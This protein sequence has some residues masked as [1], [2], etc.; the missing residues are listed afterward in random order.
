MQDLLYATAA[1]EPHF[2][3]LD[4]D[5]EDGPWMLV[6]HVLRAIETTKGLAAAIV[7][8]MLH[9]KRP[10]FVPI[11]DSKVASFTGN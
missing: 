11:F 7:T 5:D 2:E 4:L 6:R 9:R 1:S 3:T 8:K 10:N